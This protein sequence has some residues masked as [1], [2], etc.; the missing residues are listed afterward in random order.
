MYIYIYIMYMYTEKPCVFDEG[1][2]KL[3]RAARGSVGCQYQWR[4]N[5]DEAQNTQRRYQYHQIELV[6][7]RKS[8][9]GKVRRLHHLTFPRG[10]FFPQ[11]AKLCIA[12]VK[13]IYPLPVMI[14]N[15]ALI[16]LPGSAPASR[17]S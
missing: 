6:V 14:S 15:S 7:K 5:S 2:A 9:R 13:A 8:P 10:D 17:T 16:I 4:R 1:G 12:P 3:E 11:K